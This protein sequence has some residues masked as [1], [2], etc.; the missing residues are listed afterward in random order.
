MRSTTGMNFA[1]GSKRRRRGVEPVYVGQQHQKVGA[2][3]GR[4]PRGQPVVVAVADFRRRDRVVLV[5]DRHG[6]H[7]EQR[8]DRGA[9]IEIAPALLGVA[10]R[11]QDLPG[12]Q[13]ASCRA[14]PTMRRRARSARP[15][16]PPGFPRASAPACRARVWCGRARWRPTRRP[17]FPRPPAA[18]DR[19]VVG[20]RGQP[21]ALQAGR[22]VDKQRRADL[23][24]DAPV[25]LQR[26]ASSWLFLPARFAGARLPETLRA[27]CAPRAISARSTA[28]TPSPVTADSMQRRAAGGALQRRGLLLARS[29]RPACR[30]G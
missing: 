9:R 15:P 7:L 21:V 17:G 24:G 19:Y 10:E 29:R 20:E 1:A 4:D 28:S 12:F 8:R 23:D 14:P 2:H 30:P 27:P 25:F 16:P 13:A 3:H 26:L 18:S 22:A 6:L 5:D 11:Q